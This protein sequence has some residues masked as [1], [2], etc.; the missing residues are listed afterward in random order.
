M[1]SVWQ[2]KASEP[3]LHKLV[4]KYSSVKISKKTLIKDIVSK[5]N[6]KNELVQTIVQTKRMKAHLPH[7]SNPRTDLGRKSGKNPLRDELVN[8]VYKFAK[9]VTKTS[10]KV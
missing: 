3:I 2:A 6:V 4:K 9:L 10:S 8:P 1:I 7:N 5:K